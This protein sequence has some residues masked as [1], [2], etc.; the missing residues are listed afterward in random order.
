[1][2]SETKS[3]LNVLSANVFII[4]IGIVQAFILPT[5]LNPEEYGYWSLYLLYTGYAGFLIFGFCDGFYLKH[6]GEKY[7]Q[8]DKGTFSSYY[9]ILFVYLILLLGVW[10]LL[11]SSFLPLDK[12]YFVFIFVGIGVL[13]ANQRSYFVLLNQATARFSIYAKGHVIEKIVILITAI[14]GIFIYNINA[15]YIIIASI[16]GKLLTV[17][18]FSYFSKDI[19][20]SKPCINKRIAY[21]VVDNVKV[22]FTLTLSGVGGML[23]T[24]FGRFV[25]ERQ[26]GIVELGYY[27][28]MFSVSALFTQLMYAISTV[29]FP[30]FRRVKEIKAKY[31]LGRFEQLIIN[32]SGLIL[33]LYYPVRYFLEIVFPEYHPAM[34]PMLFLFPIIIFQSRKTL[35]Y[36][37][38][39][40]VLRYEK[41]LLKNVLISLAF[42]ALITIVFFSI[43]SSK[44]SV[45]FATFL[46]FLFWI[47]IAKYHY[48]RKEGVRGKWV[49]PDVVLSFIYILSNIIWDYSI[50][51]LLITICSSLLIIVVKRKEIIDI[52]KELKK[53]I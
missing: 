25:I 41:R 27:S 46:G 42:C 21:S 28:L 16:I 14:V 11:I 24:G 34:K 39:Y 49:T 20:F 37:T 45:A 48:Q 13:L 5:I 43:K 50:I 26:L 51:T 30:V 29:F 12:R 10:I 38:L 35:I 40:K 17:I 52:L 1:M 36:N 8:L 7:E 23:M 31:L 6:G 19:I 9:W 44:E 22:G 32:L 3:I 2:K 18:Y 47:F 53:C 4:L 33:I 15:F